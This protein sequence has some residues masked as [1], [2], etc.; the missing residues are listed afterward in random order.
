MGEFNPFMAENEGFTPQMDNKASQTGKW[1]S[2]VEKRRRNWNYG[3]RRLSEVRRNSKVSRRRSS[4]VRRR[5]ENG[6]AN[7]IRDTAD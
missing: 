6:V 7:R 2:Q 5:R 1:P 4:K 3:H